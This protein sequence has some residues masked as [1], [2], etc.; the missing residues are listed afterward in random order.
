MSQRVVQQSAGDMPAHVPEPE[1]FKAAHAE[2]VELL[3]ET[4]RALDAVVK[5]AGD[6]DR[7]LEKMG[8]ESPWRLWQEGRAAARAEYD[9]AVARSAT[10]S[11]K[12]NQLKSIE[13][14]LAVHVRETA[15]VIL[16]LRAVEDAERE[17]ETN[18]NNW[19]GKL[20]ERDDLLDEHCGR[21]TISSGGAIRAQVHRFSDAGAFA[22]VLRQAMSGM[23]IQGGKIEA[24]AEAICGAPDPLARWRTMLL[25]LEVLAA[26]DAARE[27]TDVPP[28]TSGLSS[29][30]LTSTEL[31]RIANG[32][33]TEQ[34]LDI[35]LTP[36]KSVPV[37]EY[38]AREGEYIPFRNASAGQQATALLKTLLNEDGPPLIIDQPE[39]D[40][41]NPVMLEIVEQLWRAKQKRQLV[42]A[43]HNANL[44]VNGDAEL[45]AWCEYRSAGDQSRG[46]IAGEGAIDITPVREAIKRIME[47]GEAA[48]NLRKE[49]YGF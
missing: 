39:E 32:L 26:F 3:A 42:F 36:I 25:E 37:F 29:A 15:A 2:Y 30:G 31:A 44:V 10:H 43:S 45:V 41:D 18:R 33:K 4:K 19:L 28:A 17:Y 21:L 27:G 9:T 34:W 35:S 6:I 40:L 13:D 14:E 47:G 24:V 46:T 49:K 23:R 12:L 38:R 11:G 8:P 20:Q 1:V 16:E 22:A 7:P 5:R 48:F